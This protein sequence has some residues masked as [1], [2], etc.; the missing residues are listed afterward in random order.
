MFTFPAR[1][2]S[3]LQYY[4]NFREYMIII[5]FYLDVRSCFATIYNVVVRNSIFFSKIFL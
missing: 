3:V 4:A 2:R 5:Q 1:Q